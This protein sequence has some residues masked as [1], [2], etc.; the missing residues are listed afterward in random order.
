[1]RRS[2][3]AAILAAVVGSAFANSASA[4]TYFYGGFVDPTNSRD[5][6]AVAHV[7]LHAPL[8]FTFTTAAPI[9]SNANILND[10]AA[11]TWW[12]ASGGQIESTISSADPKAKLTHFHIITDAAGDI[13]GF[14]IGAQATDPDFVHAGGMTPTFLF[15]SLPGS[16]SDTVRF[17]E[18]KFGQNTGGV[19]C[20]L[21][22]CSRVRTSFE[23]LPPP[24][25]GAPAVPEPA[26][27]A[28]MIVGFG[29]VGAVM[30]RRAK[31]VIG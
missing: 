23:I 21:G 13:T 12:E 24:P 19:D 29:G 22:A 10:A 1:M 9:A 17:V 6:G 16:R 30:R 20:T 14:L 26:S 18:N 2:F 27:W 3:V 28:L 8:T 31:A 4:T 15:A 5:G 11:V 7:G 25:S